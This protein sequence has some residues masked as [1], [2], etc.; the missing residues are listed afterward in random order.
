M[1][2]GWVGENGVEK[3]YSFYDYIENEIK[4]NIKRMQTSWQLYSSINKSKK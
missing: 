2:F 4:R 3:K 1:N